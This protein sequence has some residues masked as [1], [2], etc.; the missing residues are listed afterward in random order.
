[1]ALPWSNTMRAACCFLL[2]ALLVLQS[3]A[4]R[5]FTCVGSSD[6]DCNQQGSQQCPSYSDACAIIRGQASGVMKSCSY[7]SFCEQAQREGSKA[8][9]VRVQC[10][11]SDDCNSKS[12]A[13]SHMLGT[14]FLPL[15]AL[16]VLRC[17]L[18]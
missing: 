6:E 4:L 2:C 17:L 15:L 9:G 10:C 11:F 16:L 7:R 12:R 1:M 8:P 13:V 5:C 14:S 3:E 18:F